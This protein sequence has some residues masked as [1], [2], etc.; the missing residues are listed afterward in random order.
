MCS[1][2]RLKSLSR[3]VAR[4]L[5]SQDPHKFAFKTAEVTGETKTCGARSGCS[6]EE[7]GSDTHQAISVASAM[8]AP[9]GEG[10][11]EGNKGIYD[12]IICYRN[13]GQLSTVR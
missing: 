2:G 6:V 10:G 11:I 5:R 3:F 9:P 13:E 1:V 12:F 4:I 8:I 7:T